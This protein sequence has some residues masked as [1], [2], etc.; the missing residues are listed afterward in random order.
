MSLLSTVHS[1]QMVTA[2]KRNKQMKKPQVVADYDDTMGGLDRVDQHLT[3]H[4][5]LKNCGKKFVF[6]SLILLSGI[7]T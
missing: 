6:N 4:A 7:L 1:L 2:D 3:E 5:T